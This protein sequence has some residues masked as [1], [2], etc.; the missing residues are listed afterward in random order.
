MKKIL[1]FLT[2]CILSASTILPAFADGTIDVATGTG[3]GA[4]WSFSGTTITVESAGSY[5]LTGT[6]T[7]N[8]IVVKAGLTVNIT[9][10]D[11]NI[12]TAR[13]FY[14]TPSNTTVNLTLDGVNTLTSISGGNAGLSVHQNT[15]LNIDGHGSLTA[16]GSVNGENGGAGI[17]SAASTSVGTININ[18][19]TIT[20]ISLS[21]AA[22]I[23][24]G[25]H[26]NYGTVTVSGGVVTANGAA[27]GIG[28]YNPTAQGGTFTLNGNGI[29]FTNSVRDN[30]ASR[31]T[32]GAI[33]IGNKS[34]FYGTS[35]TPTENLTIPEGK[36]FTIPEGATVTIPAGKTL[37]N[38]GSI[39]VDGT[40]IVNGNLTNNGTLTVDNIAELNGTTA[41]AGLFTIYGKATN[42]GTLTNTGTIDGTINGNA[43][44]VEN[45]SINVGTVNASGAGYTFANNVITLTNLDA[46]Y[47]LTGTTSA[48]RVEVASGINVN[49]TFDNID[50]TTST[51]SAFYINATS[52]AHITLEGTNNLT[53]S[54]TSATAPA[55]G[56]PVN[57]SV[58]IDGAGALNVVATYGAGIGSAGYIPAGTITINNG[59][60]Y[61]ESKQ[62]ASI[63]GQTGTVAVN[64]GAITTKARIGKPGIGGTYFTMNGNGVV[65]ATIIDDASQK[66]SGVIFKNKVGTVYGSNVTLDNSF[67][68]PSGNTLT[69]EGGKTLTV[70]TGTTLTNEGIINIYGELAIDGSVVNNGQIN[71]YGK[72][73]GTVSGNSVVDVARTTYTIDLATVNASAAGYTYD[74]G[75]LTLTANNAQYILSGS[76]TTTSVVVA[77]GLAVN[78][79]LHDVNIESNQAFLIS[80]TSTANITLEGANTLTSTGEN[81][82]GLAVPANAKLIIDGT[83]SLVAT[84][85]GGNN[86]GGAGIG[87]NSNT[88]GGVIII[89][90]GIITAYGSKKAA[91]IGGGY[92]SGYQEIAIN[93]GFVNAIGVEWAGTKGDGIGGYG[94]ST[95]VF[96]MNGNGVVIASSI[97]DNS[98]KTQGL[99][100]TQS[101]GVLYGSNSVIDNNLTFPT[102]ATLTVKAGQTLTINAGDTLFLPNNTVLTLNAG[103]T[104]VNNGVIIAY[105]DMSIVENGDITGSGKIE[106]KTTDYDNRDRLYFNFHIM[107]DILYNDNNQKTI[108]A[109]QV[110]SIQSNIVK[111][112][113]FLEQH[114][115]N[116]N[117]VTKTTIYDDQRPA[118]YD[119][120]TEWF[121]N[122][123]D[124]DPHS[125]DVVVATPSGGTTYYEAYYAGSYI[126]LKPSW[127][128]NV[129]MHEFAH[130][131]QSKITGYDPDDG[132]PWYTLY[133]RYDTML[134]SQ[135]G[136]LITDAD[137][138]GEGWDGDNNWIYTDDNPQ[139]FPQNVVFPE[140]ATLNLG[141]NL[142]AAVFA[143]GSGD[144]TFRFS[145]GYDPYTSNYWSPSEEENG[146]AF[147]VVFIPTD[148]TTYHQITSMVP[149]RLNG[150]KLDVELYV[151]QNDVAQAQTPSPIIEI[152]PV[153]LKQYT[154]V[155]YKV[156]GADNSAFST[157]IPTAAGK[158]T[159][160]VRFDGDAVYNPVTAYDNFT[161]SS[162]TGI[163]NVEAEETVKITSGEGYIKVI[164]TEN[165]S[166]TQL[167]KV[168][169]LTGSLYAAKYLSGSDATISAKRGLYIVNCGNAR[170]KVIVK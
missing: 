30:T 7:E 91:G 39:I 168:Y 98:P 37:Q 51:E 143:G 53:V 25:Y 145:N 138:V 43:V 152:Y 50:I 142:S 55:L 32:S 40:L 73:T 19:G 61:A 2:A 154:V 10:Q 135:W 22:G 127:G 133:Q 41:N 29:V 126:Y 121:G 136:K 49:V 153:E 162:T 141:Q 79:T 149:I 88:T 31:R 94:N 4:G 60:I 9:L 38:N 100:F 119:G 101:I 125:M 167:I 89:N 71:N 14:I 28:N 113:K 159:V 33:L 97:N 23:G 62:A 106:I 13:P 140:Y 151:V 52:S 146:K 5:T 44:Y 36:I 11:V 139:S 80:A 123:I 117:V 65:F 85:N 112:E 68:I 20:A 109:S 99:L 137:N 147:R 103:S 102:G 90:D 75:T 1:Y 130:H 124:A 163:A 156:Q 161:I 26:G 34:L 8:S 64:G 83:G 107:K 35:I 69:I 169:T 67:T 6:T 72:V 16:T 157:T 57:A 76:T 47:T 108:S 15:T 128:P 166:K 93:G 45:Y 86:S 84:G 160:R 95:G 17:G 150:I 12:Q 96:T 82:A 165:S 129:L 78:I 116:V 46:F 114:S 111:F 115:P 56:V 158:Y 54:G 42:N 131:I 118:T 105:Q 21:K 70:G 74:N 77:S 18:S 48:N 148:G 164:N 144:G 170:K 110:T 120:S 58:I 132:A 134:I 66:T 155:E 63:G 3:S 122:S 81:S 87:G 92:H 24:G 59:I 27:D 104:L